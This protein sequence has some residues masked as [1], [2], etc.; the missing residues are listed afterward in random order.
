V[1]GVEEKFDV[2][3]KELTQKFRNLQRLLHP[4]KFSQKSEQE[5]EYSASHSSL[6][7]KAYSIIAKPLARGLYLLALEEED[8][9]GKQDL[10]QDF[11]GLIM[12][13]NEELIEAT[14]S[15]D[16]LQRLDKK[17]DKVL[18]GLVDQIAE[19]FR[20]NDLDKAKALLLKVK[21]YDN[22]DSKVKNMIQEFSNILS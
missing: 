8:L 2:D 6:V 5:K 9:E 19:A 13:L 14:D 15:L 12:E 17:N 10:D 3:P 1:L 22:I 11:L 7:N 20:A 18:K 4:D 21:Y 16:E